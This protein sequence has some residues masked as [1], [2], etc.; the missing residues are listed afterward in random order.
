[1]V[2]DA[3]AKGIQEVCLDRVGRCSMGN[4]TCA[5]YVVERTQNGIFRH[6]RTVLAW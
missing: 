2:A 1:M 3:T 5:A 6:A 4:L